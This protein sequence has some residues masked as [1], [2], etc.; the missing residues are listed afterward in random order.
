MVS[1]ELRAGPVR[2]VPA[3]VSLGVLL[4]GPILLP[5]LPPEA[6]SPVR[7][8][9]GGGRVGAGPT[10]PVRVHRAED[11]PGVLP[12]GSTASRETQPVR[13]RGP[14]GA[15]PD[16]GQGSQGRPGIIIAIQPYGDRG[17]F[18][19]HLHALVTDGTF[20]PNSSRKAAKG[21]KI[22]RIRLLPDCARSEEPHL[23]A[24]GLS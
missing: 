20:S 6:G 19:P 18:H 11:G 3:R 8:M 22:N 7:E 13:R 24:L 14:D 21:A 5:L 16:S 10:S 15:L 17:N 4:Q 2:Y 12:E 23:N 1:P 9:G